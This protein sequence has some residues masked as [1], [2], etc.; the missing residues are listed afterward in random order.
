MPIQPPIDPVRS[1]IIE[2]LQMERNYCREI[3]AW[4]DALAE[5]GTE[6]NGVPEAADLWCY[7]MD[8]MGVPKE[9]PTFEREWLSEKWLTVVESND[10]GTVRIENYLNWVIAEV[11]GGKQGGGKPQKARPSQ[12]PPQSRKH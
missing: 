4:S 2:L 10:E 1:I 6:I 11:N 12:L 9:S 7:A 8:L 5:A 3:M